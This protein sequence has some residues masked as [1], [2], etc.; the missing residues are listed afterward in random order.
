MGILIAEGLSRVGCS[1]P[2]TELGWEY[3]RG[4]YPASW[5]Q[6]SGRQEKL[7]YEWRRPFDPKASKGQQLDNV[8][9]FSS[10]F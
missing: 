4:K 10:L 2:L 5:T 7:W 3:E 8:R 1:Q 9:S 6:K